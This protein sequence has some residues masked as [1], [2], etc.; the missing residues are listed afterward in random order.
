MN[1]YTFPCMLLVFNV[2][3]SCRTLAGAIL[4]I[5]IADDHPVVRRGVC[6]ILE[7]RKDLEVCAE[8]GDGE[9]AVQKAVELKP[10]AVI[11]DVCGFRTMPISVPGSCRSLIPSDVDQ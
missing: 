6:S 11:L 9:E 2:M 3:Q 4:R 5:L 1:L 7:T 10:D 8:A